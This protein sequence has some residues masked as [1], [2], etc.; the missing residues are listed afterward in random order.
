MDSGFRRNDE[1]EAGVATGGGVTTEV[2]SLRGG[3]KI[4]RGNPVVYAR[5]FWIASLCSQ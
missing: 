4:R 3:L 5:L 2:V 1:R